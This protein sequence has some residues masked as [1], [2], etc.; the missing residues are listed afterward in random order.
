MNTTSSAGLRAFALA[1]LSTPNNVHTVP[2]RIVPS[3]YATVI[4]A[5]KLELHSHFRF[6]CLALFFPLA[7]TLM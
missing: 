4:L 7:L 3:V 2:S 1:L 5:M 6:P